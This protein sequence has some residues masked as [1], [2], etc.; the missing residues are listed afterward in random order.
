MLTKWNESTKGFFQTIRFVKPARP[1]PSTSLLSIFRNSPP[2]PTPATIPRVSLLHFL[3]PP[4]N[5]SFSKTLRSSQILATN[6]S[7]QVVPNKG[8]TSSKME[9]HSAQ[10]E[11]SAYRQSVQDGSG[12]RELLEKAGL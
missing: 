2:L 3:D 10:N 12:I 1:A 9:L 6:C 4:N 5:Y 7:H 8:W 11:D